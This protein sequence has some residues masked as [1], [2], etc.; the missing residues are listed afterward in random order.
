V[1]FRVLKLKWPADC[2]VCGAH[3]STGTPAVWNPASR[4]VCCVGCTE[5]STTRDARPSDPTPAN[6]TL[7][8]PPT[9]PP[10]DRGEAGASVHREHERRR[11]RRERRTR[12]AHP[13]IG[14]LLLALRGTPNHELAFRSGEHGERAVAQS[15]ERRTAHGPA[16]VLHDRRM[17]RGRGNIDHIAIAPAGIYVIDA[18]NHK[19]K[20]R[21]VHPLFNPPRLVI[22]GR[23]W[24]RLL[25]GLDR[26]LAAV[27]SALPATN[28]G[29]PLQGVL[30]FTNADLPPLGPREMRN[31]LLLHPRALAKRLNAPGPLDTPTIDE[32][33]RTLAS[34]LA[35]A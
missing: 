32:L 15:L 14:G 20:V 7:N 9:P 22:A 25:D 6:P 26:Q 33:A 8:V 24:T 34:A 23:N 31:H 4:K 29:I 3:L 12:E 28:S 21:I 27:R 19:G 13:W 18:K 10:L 11:Q 1:P 17:P 2:A 5:L 30:C 16:I 35:P